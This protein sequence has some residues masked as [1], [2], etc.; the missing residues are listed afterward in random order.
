MNNRFFEP[1]Q[2]SK[3]LKR[4][5]LSK[6]NP[7]RDKNSLSNYKVTS[8]DQESSM[9]P[10]EKLVLFLNKSYKTFIPRHY[11]K[12]ERQK[13][14]FK[15][16][17]KCL[18]KIKE[19]IYYSWDDILNGLKFSESDYKEAEFFCFHL[20]KKYSEKPKYFLKNW[21]EKIKKFIDLFE[22]AMDTKQEPDLVK[23]E[24]LANIVDEFNK[25]QQRTFWFL[26]QLPEFLDKKSRLI[27]KESH[28]YQEI[29]KFGAFEYLTKLGL[30]LQ[31]EFNLTH[32][33]IKDKVA[34]NL[35]QELGETES[36]LRSEIQRLELENQELENKIETIKEESFQEAVYKLAQ[37]LQN[38]QQQPVLAQI[39]NL[40][41]RLENLVENG[42]HLSNQDTLTCLISIES[43]LEAFKSLNLT[44]FPQN[45]N[46]VFE[47]TGMDLDTNKYNYTSGTQFTKKEEKKKVKCVAP[48]WCVGEQIVTPA[49]V[50]EI[51]HN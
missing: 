3:A 51:E 47:I 28:G 36:N 50:E 31:E 23:L 4:P 5:K 39:F 42:Q 14:V 24:E 1:K 6:S 30:Q 16:Q 2:N 33:A 26:Y 29:M 20:S 13:E 10:W 7:K 35:V 45:I 46:Q 27:L 48:G 18:E 44:P 37:L 49:K 34:Q 15:I 21:E 40:Y 11:D 38:N 9:K 25:S 19:N 43:L 41:Q 8:C 17:R 12:Q 32:T 22:M